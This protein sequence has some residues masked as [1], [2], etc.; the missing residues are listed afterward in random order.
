MTPCCSIDY[1]VMSRS[2]LKEYQEPV[3]MMINM[4]KDENDEQKRMKD[5]V[6]EVAQVCGIDE[7]SEEEKRRKVL[8]RCRELVHM[9]EEC[10]NAVMQ[11]REL[12]DD[13][14]SCL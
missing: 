4:I 8:L 10:R 5:W 3:E 7:E 14:A 2:L 9:E 6:N 11:W 13:M 12:I 1:G